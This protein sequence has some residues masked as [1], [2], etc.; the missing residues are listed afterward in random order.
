MAPAL[1][2]LTNERDRH[3]SRNP[4]PQVNDNMR[5]YPGELASLGRP[6]LEGE[7]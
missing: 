2:E 4:I 7:N 6:G 1:M 5:A 3:E